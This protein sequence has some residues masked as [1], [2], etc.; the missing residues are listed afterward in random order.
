MK[1][2]N[3]MKINCRRKNSNLTEEKA[4]SKGVKT[5][6]VIEKTEQP[7]VWEKDTVEINQLN[8]R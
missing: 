8:K 6:A 2:L 4:S 7:S 1:Q 3:L 5:S